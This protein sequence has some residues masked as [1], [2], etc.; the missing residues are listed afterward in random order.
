MLAILHR[1][2]RSK[3]MLRSLPMEWHR[4]IQRQRLGKCHSTAN[5]KQ[6]MDTNNNLTC[7]QWHQQWLLHLMQ[8]RLLW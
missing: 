7:H 6:L 5:L 8:M 4:A 1:V 2:M 3:G